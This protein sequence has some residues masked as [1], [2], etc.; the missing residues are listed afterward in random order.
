MFPRLLFPLDGSP[1]AAQTVPYATALA[2][3][4]HSHVVLLSVLGPAPV[5]VVHFP[6]QEAAARGPRAWWRRHFARS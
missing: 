3:A 5:A 6:E 4:F 1:V 2:H